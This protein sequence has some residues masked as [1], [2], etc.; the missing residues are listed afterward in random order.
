M[1]IALVQSLPIGGAVDV[2]INVE[3]D[4][5]W[6]RVLRKPGA[7][8]AVVFS[9]TTDTAAVRVVDVAVT[10]R[11]EYY[12]VA[13]V[14]DYNNLSNSST[15]SYAA[16]G[17]N[18]TTA[19]WSSSTV[20]DVTVT[21]SADSEGPDPLDF[22]VSRINNG[23]QVEVSA[24]RLQPKTG[25]IPVV[26]APPQ[27]ANTPMPIVSV[28][29]D[30]DSSAERFIGEQVGKEVAVNPDDPG[31]TDD[32]SRYW[33]DSEGWLSRWTS[34]I[35]G[36]SQNPDE[37]NSLRKSLKRIIMG[38]LPIFDEAGMLQV[39]L[40]INDSEELEAFG[41]PLYMTVQTVTCLAPAK[42]TGRFPDIDDVEITQSEFGSFF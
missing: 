4:I 23:L 28:H 5:S 27:T 6:L 26:T 22:L 15:Y 42:L 13:S 16:F 41:I 17:Y 20:I 34:T 33:L 14:I 3:S 32:T 21:P 40:S 11:D 36:W 7:R 24:Q 9:G 19:L 10:P 8:G 2:S 1:E 37:R 29:L 25:R 39:D 30:I 31:A 38:N 35:T 18:S 12:L